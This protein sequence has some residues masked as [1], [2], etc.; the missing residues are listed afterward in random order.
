MD[1]NDRKF[2]FRHEV[3]LGDDGG[4][5]TVIHNARRGRLRRPA[6]EVPELRRARRA[7]LAFV[8]RDAAATPAAATLSASLTLTLTLTLRRARGWLLTCTLRDDGGTGR[9]RCKKNENRDPVSHAPQLI[10]VLKRTGGSRIP[11]VSWMSFKA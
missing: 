10:A 6:E 1:V 2:R 8:D 11:D 5:R 4:T 3:R 7:L 9:D